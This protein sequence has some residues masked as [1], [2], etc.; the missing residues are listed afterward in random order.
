M[1][2]RSLHWNLPDELWGAVNAV[3]AGM[4]SSERKTFASS[5]TVCK[6]CLLLSSPLAAC[7]MPHTLS[8]LMHGICVIN[9]QSCQWNAGVIYL[10]MP[11]QAAASTQSASNMDMPSHLP[12]HIQDRLNQRPQLQGKQVTIY[13]SSGC[14]CSQHSQSKVSCYTLTVITSGG[15]V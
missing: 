3:S 9:L 12:Q 4:S 10:D 5:S 7:I 11:Q 14:S 2:R 1:P 6:V 15:S 8:I 13:R